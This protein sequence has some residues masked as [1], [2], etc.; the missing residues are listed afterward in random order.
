MP[1][2]S[3]AVQWLGLGA[4]TAR[5]WVQSLFRELRSHK[6]RQRCQKKEKI[7]KHKKNTVTKYPGTGERARVLLR[8]T[9]FASVY[10][11]RTYRTF[12]ARHCPKSSYQTISFS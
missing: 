9:L 10:V 1:E 11:T 7:A 6:D 2:N 8:I 3:L 4:F 5:A 12:C